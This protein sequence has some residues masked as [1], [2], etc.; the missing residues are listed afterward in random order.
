MK[1][2]CLKVVSNSADAAESAIS[3][4]LPG[5][6]VRLFRYRE[7][8]VLLAPHLL[9]ALQLQY[10]PAGALA[11]L[12][13]AGLV[14]GKP[15]RW[16]EVIGWAQVN[17]ETWA[18]HEVFEPMLAHSARGLDWHLAL[19][20][21]YRA[22]ISVGGSDSIDWKSVRVGQIDTGY[23]E[24]PVFGFPKAPWTDVAGART[25]IPDPPP[26]GGLDTLSGPSGG[27]G[28]TSASICCGFDPAA[29]YFGVAPRVP[30]VP[31]RISDCVILDERADEFEAAA[32]YLVDDARVS[33]INV[34]MG[35]FLKFTPPPPIARALD[36][37]Y[38]RGVILVAAAGNVPAPEWPAYPAALPRAIA[39][40]GVT[41]A[42]IPW[43]MSSYGPG[44]DFSAPADS[45]RRAATRTGPGFGYTDV[46]DGTTFA[47][48]MTSGAA[49]LW[50]LKHSA[51]ITQRFTEP[52]QRIEAFRLMAR[53]S[54]W[55]PPWWLADQGFGAGILDVGGLMDPRRLPSAAE[56]VRR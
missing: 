45:V 44:V 31:A 2:M 9:R 5:L 17:I 37:C 16:R 8:T 6:D 19:C 22:W 54:A 12:E 13:S 47:T 35:T 36:H 52:W 43:Y 50:L 28:T 55:V 32:R 48:A 53:R 30:L 38:E 34:S 20:N 11:I 49:A 25:F 56:L 27:H 33:V 41:R 26:G 15:V 46:G 42:A 21:V 4:F 39:V 18:P 3:H 1:P 14:D 24:H 23:T 7:G 29:G 10:G 40:A 51:M